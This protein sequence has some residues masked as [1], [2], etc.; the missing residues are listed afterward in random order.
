[1]WTKKSNVEHV[2]TIFRWIARAI[3]ISILSIGCVRLI[4][5]VLLIRHALVKRSGDQVTEPTE[6]PHETSRHCPTFSTHINI[7]ADIAVDIGNFDLDK[8][9]SST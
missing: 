8:F 1:M 9:G 6:M 7:T 4:R 2:L 5:F 3:I